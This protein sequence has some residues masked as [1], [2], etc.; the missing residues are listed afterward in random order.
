MAYYLA[1]WTEKRL[2]K[3][4]NRSGENHM[5]KPLKMGLK[6]ENNCGPSDFFTNGSPLWRRLLIVRSTTN[7]L[8]YYQS[9]FSPAIPVVFWWG[10]GE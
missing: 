5:H 8:C 1:R 2:D 4:T 7:V 10:S 3:L 6:Y 9:A